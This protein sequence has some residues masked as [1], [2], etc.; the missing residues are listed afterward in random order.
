[1]NFFWGR[2]SYVKIMFLL[3]ITQFIRI[4]AENFKIWSHLNQTYIGK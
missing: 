1:M 2:A 4:F 3:A